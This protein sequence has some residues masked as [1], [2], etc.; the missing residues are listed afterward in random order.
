MSLP[1]FFENSMVPVWLSKISPIEIDAITLGPLVFNRGNMGQTTKNHETI[2]WAQYKECLIIGFP[3]LYGISYFINRCKGM[4]G[5][6][7]YRNIWFEKEA[8]D[9]QAD[10]EYLHKRKLYT[11]V[12]KT[13]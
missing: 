4:S 10:F 9:N 3:I 8:Y 13:T 7:A 2:H 11:W 6:E 1:L 5:A 12:K